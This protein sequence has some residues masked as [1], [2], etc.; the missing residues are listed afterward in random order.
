MQSW[1]AMLTPLMGLAGALA[2]ALAREAATATGV[3]VDN[4]YESKTAAAQ[5]MSAKN[6]PI[7]RAFETT[8]GRGLPG[9]INNLSFQFLKFSLLIFKILIYI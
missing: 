5:F 1:A 3:S 7:T 9:V 2:D 4:L 6:N 8:A